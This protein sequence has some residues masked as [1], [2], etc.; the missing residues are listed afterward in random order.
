MFVWKHNF[1][2]NKCRVI[3]IANIKSIHAKKK[4]M[5]VLY[6]KLRSH[7]VTYMSKKSIKFADLRTFY[8]LPVIARLIKKLNNPN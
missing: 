2:M 7:L 4:S 3:Q 1:H 5:N 6:M 8:T